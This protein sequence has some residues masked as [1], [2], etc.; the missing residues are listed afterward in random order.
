MA[1]AVVAYARVSFDDQERREA[2]V[3]VGVLELPN[4]NISSYFQQNITNAQSSMYLN[5]PELQNKP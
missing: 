5:Y 2:Y 3:N 1:G 4:I